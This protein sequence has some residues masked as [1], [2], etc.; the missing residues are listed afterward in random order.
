MTS[1]DQLPD[2]ARD[3]NTSGS[4]VSSRGASAAG[5]AEP[6]PLLYPR[7]GIL[8]GNR[9]RLADRIGRGASAE[10]WRGWDERLSRPVAVKIFRDSTEGDPSARARRSGEARLLAALSHQHLVAIY[11][12]AGFGAEREVSWMAMEFVDGPTLRDVLAAG[13]LPP[14]T[15]AA[16][17]RQLADALDYVHR[18]GAI[19]RDVKPANVLLANLPGDSAEGPDAQAEPF[20]KL[21]DFGV[22]RLLD[23]THLTLEGFTIGTANYLSPEQVTGNACG[24]AVDVYA[25]GLVLLESLTGKI[26]Y[27]GV[28]AE[29]ALVRLHRRP[30]IPDWLPAQWRT[31]LTAMTARLPTARPSLT[32]VRTALATLAADTSASAAEL[33]TSTRCANADSPVPSGLDDLFPTDLVPLALSA[34]DDEAANASTAAEPVDAGPQRPSW[35]RRRRGALLLAAAAAVVTAVATPLAFGGSAEPT[36]AAAATAPSRAPGSH[37]GSQNAAGSHRP[38]SR[39][40]RLVPAADIRDMRVMHARHHR[41]HVVVAI[42]RKKRAVAPH[43]RHRVHVRHRVQRHRPSG[44]P[45]PHGPPPPRAAPG[46]HERPGP[47]KPAPPKP[48]KTKPHAKPDGKHGPHHAAPKPPPDPKKPLQR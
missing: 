27:P 19:H 29:A 24:P 35:R 4:A 18:R 41:A 10:V 1:M 43:R 48:P 30:H 6:D 13:P 44:K 11:D 7:P 31:L 32:V 25:L 45:A 22:A 46:P 3:A 2:A 8:A 23:D 34:D 12:A 9:Y 5:Q 16:I 42:Q 21:T 26:A 20:V 39:P 36:E 40:A 38:S 15:V 47:P 17:G 28:G 37:A 33:A 14:A